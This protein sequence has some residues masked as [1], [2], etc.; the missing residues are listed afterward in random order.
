MESVYQS[1][2][3]MTGKYRIDFCNLLQYAA[4][5]PGTAG[6]QWLTAEQCILHRRSLEHLFLC[7]HFWQGWM[8]G[9]QAS[10][11]TGSQP[12]DGVR[13]CHIHVNKQIN[14]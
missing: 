13:D 6:T 14:T 1:S 10:E 11:D 7:V 5:P 9:Q 8:E 2:G 3:L 4:S 12:C